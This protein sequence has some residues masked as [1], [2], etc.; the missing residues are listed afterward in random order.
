MVLY[1]CFL[2]WAGQGIFEHFMHYSFAARILLTCIALF[3]LGFLL[4]IYFPSGLELIDTKYKD[5]IAW[6]W[7]LNSGFS[8]LG[9]ITAIILAQFLGF[10]FILLIAC[11]IY[12]IALWSFSKWSTAVHQG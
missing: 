8:V 4:G 10:S 1:I 6:A 11:L 2:I 5:S 9:S 7:A 12:I 3:P